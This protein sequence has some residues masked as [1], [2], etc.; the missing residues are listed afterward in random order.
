MGL[1]LGQ[2]VQELGWDEDVDDALRDDIMDIIDAEMIEEPLEA[3]DVVVLWW[4]DEDGDVA[5]GLVDAMTDLSGNGWIWLLT[6]KVGRPGFIDPASIAEGVTV[7]GLSLT[8]T[9]NCADD[10]QATRVVRPKGARR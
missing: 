9:A 10:W 5:D 4:R 7:A 8:S 3:V 2:V 1:A 6:P